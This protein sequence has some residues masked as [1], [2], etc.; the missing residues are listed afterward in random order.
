MRKELM[1][2]EKIIGEG[3]PRALARGHK[4]RYLAEYK[5]GPEFDMSSLNGTYRMIGGRLLENTWV[6]Q[7]AF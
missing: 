7:S 6:F 1:F 4:G 5:I 2:W 3:N